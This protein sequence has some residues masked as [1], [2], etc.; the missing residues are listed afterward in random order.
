MHNYVQMYF[1]FRFGSVIASSWLWFS[2]PFTAISYLNSSCLFGMP[3]LL[4]KN[5]EKV[6]WY[7]LFWK[8]IQTALWRILKHACTINIIEEQ[9]MQVK[10]NTNNICQCVEVW[11]FLCLGLLRN[12]DRNFPKNYWFQSENL[13]LQTVFHESCTNF[14]KMIQFFTWILK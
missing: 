1:L 13:S 14:V 6:N 4:H 8:S 11:T 3:F 5:D 2:F 9:Q 12:L 10:K 7:H